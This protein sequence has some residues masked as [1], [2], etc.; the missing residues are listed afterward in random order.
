MTNGARKTCQPK[1]INCRA[2]T[3]IGSGVPNS[4]PGV[5][6]AATVPNPG[7][8][9]VIA[10]S[11]IAS[12]A[13]APIPFTNRLTFLE[14]A[15]LYGGSL[16]TTNTY[17][18]DFDS[19]T[20]FSRDPTGDMFCVGGAF[21][22]DGSLFAFG[23]SPVDG[24]GEAVRV[25]KSGA[26]WA[27]NDKLYTLQ[28][29]RWYPTGLV[30][31]NGQ[32]A[33]IGGQ[34][35]G[36]RVVTNEP[37]VEFLPNLQNRL[38]TLDLLVNSIGNNLY[39]YAYI[40]V[41]AQGVE[42]A[43]VFAR[44]SSCLY[45]PYTFAL[46][47]CLPNVPTAGLRIGNA[48]AGMLP[49]IAGPGN[50][51]PL[52]RIIICG[53]TNAD[54][55]V[56]NCILTTP[57]LGAAA[58]WT[59]VTMPFGRILGDMVSL[60]DGTLLLLNGASRGNA[61]F[62]GLTAPVLTAVLYNPVTNQFSVLASTTIARLYHNSAVLLA[63]G[64]VLVTSSTPNE[65]ADIDNSL[66]IYPTERRLETFSPPYLLTAQVAPTINVVST[67]TWGYGQQITIRATIPSGNTAG[68]VVR[69][70]NPGFGKFYL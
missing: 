14:R 62:A 11:P 32:V 64:R 12:L 46:I 57:A 25:L 24:V 43:W 40:V 30:L 67:T 52:K 15:A 4:I 51:Y 56:N 65:N 44:A 61:D 39:P 31:P 45:N 35:R 55:A 23:G 8:Y 16:G 13:V 7:R 22:P 60:P 10:V 70:I 29:K 3:D 41:N 2:L 37:T 34:P 68:V 48:P 26:E 9:D 36:L 54:A 49:Q 20:F 50:V 17:D 66:V 47:Q 6:F 21:N 18:F 27:Q 19:K 33:V 53:G 58:I 28:R 59:T 5:T 38:V 42:M 69:L 1:S 63:D